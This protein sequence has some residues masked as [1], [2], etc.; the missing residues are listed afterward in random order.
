MDLSLALSP[1]GPLAALGAHPQFILYRVQPSPSRP[2]K[3]DKFPIDWQTLA[4][5][6]A[7][8]PAVWMDAATAVA[9]AAV[10]GPEYGIGWVLTEAARVWFL[11][12]D[13]CLT[14]TGWSP[15]ATT[16]CQDLAGCAVE[17]SQSG[18]GL[19]LF[20]SLDTT[21]AHRCRNIP[22]NLE[23]YT[24]GRFVALTGTHA[25]GDSRTR[26]PSLPTVISE[27]FPPDVADPDRPLEW[28]DRPR[29]GYNTTLLD[30]STL[31]HRMLSQTSASAAFG[32]KATPADLWLRNVARLS[33][34]FPDP[35][36]Q[37]PYDASSADSSLA[38]HLAF[39]TG[40]DCARIDRL[41]RLSALVRDKWTDR[42]DYLPRTILDAVRKTT[43]YPKAP[44][45][46]Q[47][48]TLGESR[49]QTPEMLLASDLAAH[50]EGCIYI[51]DR[52]AAAAPDGTIL[53]PEQ[54][55]AS[56]RYGGHVFPF[57]SGKTTKDAW[58]A[59]QRNSPLVY[60]P[61]HAHGLCFRPELPPRSIVN[62]DGRRMF[63]SYVPVET[64]ATAGDAAPFLNLL[65]KMYPV[66]SDFDQLIAY[67]ASLVQNPGVKFQWAPLLQ[68]TPGN[69]KTFLMSCLEYCVSPRYTHKPNSQDL[70]NKFNGWA[71]GNLLILVEEVYVKDRRDLLDALKPFITNTRIEIQRKRQ[72]QVTGDNRANYVLATNHKDAIPKT[73]DDRRYAVYFAAQ[74]EA[75]D[76][77]RDGM[78][79]MYFPELWDWARGGGY[80]IVN[81]FLRT[82]EI[83][84]ALDP[85]RACHRAP[86]TSSTQEAIEIG[87][88]SVEQ[89]ILEAAEDGLSGFAGGWVSISALSGLLDRNHLTGRVSRNKMRTVLRSIGYIPHPGLPDG[90]THNAVE[91][92]A[93]RTRL[94]VRLGHLSL[95]L[96]DAAAICKAY[97]NAQ[98]TAAM[99][100]F[101][102]G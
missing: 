45:P 58:E 67:F 84:L 16:L 94:Y 12:I 20:G 36:G 24:S 93:V 101:A 73:D 82:Y 22:L 11:D 95:G 14:E 51:E 78:S 72:D 6:N 92:D 1:S 71:E 80:A 55:R 98:P 7:H 56:G 40:G 69:G 65:R 91:P 81:H 38:H 87:R 19:H 30:D 26:A 64:V 62:V 44:M 28:T 43:D 86:V 49:P 29:E 47:A 50:F 41:M 57:L 18:R 53:T 48:P 85:A 89:A 63:N 97:T 74:Q 90:R 5:A 21:P 10:Y 100:V 17:V 4:R 76:L 32:T 25:A 68:G 33:V 66:P 60:Q 42:A 34:A 13:E 2:G 37:R 102:H 79:G 39:W 8:D 75:D 15:L 83:P 59:F 96:T 46:G 35:G 52:V 99:G 61:S 88:G 23:F 31:I 54:F 70:A 77:I 9:M 27:Y 3:S